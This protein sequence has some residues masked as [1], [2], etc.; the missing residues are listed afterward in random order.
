MFD[1]GFWELLLIFGVGLLILGPER[2]PR[3][4]SQLGRWIGRAR[5]TA[6]SLRRQLEQEIASADAPPPPPKR[7][8][9]P[10]KPVNRPVTAEKK[11]SSAAD[12][13]Q[14]P[15]AGSA[16]GSAAAPA[17]GLQP[18]QDHDDSADGS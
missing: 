13:P 2:M 15:A 9:T 3:V 1:V 7:K 10:V 8:P 17:Q 5:R 11:A 14:T 12:D 6:S 16:A 18:A 4:A